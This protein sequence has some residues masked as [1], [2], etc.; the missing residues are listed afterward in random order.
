MFL[1]GYFHGHAFTANGITNFQVIRD[2]DPKFPIIAAYELPDYSGSQW[3][4]IEETLRL[5]LQK[6]EAC[7]YLMI[8]LHPTI[9]LLAR[10]KVTKAIK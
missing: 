3:N 4:K 7:F 10:R 1:P 9:P 6:M 2:A 8:L 5:Y